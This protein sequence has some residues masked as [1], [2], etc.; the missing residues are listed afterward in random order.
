MESRSLL[1]LVPHLLVIGSVGTAFVTGHVL[2]RSL[3]LLLYCVAAAVVAMSFALIMTD[4]LR[5][6]APFDRMLLLSHRYS[7]PVK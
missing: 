3:P 7:E 5:F 4:W 6:P 1:L 2:D